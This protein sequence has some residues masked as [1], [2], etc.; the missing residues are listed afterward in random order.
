MT[1]AARRVTADDVVLPPKLDVLGV[2]VS[3]TTMPD[4]IQ[5]IDGSVQ[6]RTTIDVSFVN[7]N[8]VMRAREDP[9]LASL[10]NAFDVVLADGWGVVWASRLLGDPLRGR[11]ANDDIERPL[12][13]LADAN[14]YRVFLFGSGPGV[15]E[16]AADRLA[17][18]FPGLAIVG[19]QHGWLDVDR[20]HPG[21]IEDADSERVVRRI[22]AARPDILVVG[23]PTPL[24]QRWVH[25][26]RDRLAVPVVITGGS[27]LDHVAER[28]GWYPR[29]VTAARLC[30]AYRLAREPRR[31]WRR[32]TVELGTFAAIVMAQAARARVRRLVPVRHT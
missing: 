3:R 9:D 10:I 26:Y 17:S 18:T 27:Y 28:I 29:W 19:T 31:L 25:A 8:Y 1:I 32:Y 2:R 14:G 12:F 6:S 23:L 7:P 5:L 16:A 22:E 15:A 24:Q 21:L 4:L 11:L 13:D 20:G 30:W